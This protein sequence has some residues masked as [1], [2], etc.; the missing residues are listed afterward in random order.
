MREIQ[1]LSPHWSSNAAIK[2]HGLLACVWLFVWNGTA[3]GEKPLPLALRLLCLS[4]GGPCFDLF[5][6]LESCW[7]RVP[8][9]NK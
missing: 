2:F 1:R 8:I 5:I 4:Q 9:L 7:R 6:L 3:R